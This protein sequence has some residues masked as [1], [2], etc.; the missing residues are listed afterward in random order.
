MAATLTSQ[1]DKVLKL[2]QPYGTLNVIDTTRQSKVNSAIDVN[3]VGLFIH[4]SR[5]SSPLTLICL[6]V[7]AY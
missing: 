2:E 3:T 5:E 1:A 6:Y 7:G 4:S